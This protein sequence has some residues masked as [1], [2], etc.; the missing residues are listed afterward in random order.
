MNRRDF[1]LRMIVVAGLLLAWMAIYAAS[2]YAASEE[3]LVR[4]KVGMTKGEVVLVMGK[5]DSHGDKK[6]DD[7]CSCFTYK[8]V[9]RYKYINVWFD[10]SDKLVAIDKAA[11]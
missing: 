5:P 10:C 1:R 9:G 8:N 3:D 6:G 11:K 7:L 4:L 2:A